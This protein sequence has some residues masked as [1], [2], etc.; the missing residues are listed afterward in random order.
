MNVKH[1]K[2]IVECYHYMY[3]HSIYMLHFSIVSI[4]FCCCIAKTGNQ[5]L[6]KHVTHVTQ[7][8]DCVVLKSIGKSVGFFVILYD[9]LMILTQ[10]AYIAYGKKLCSILQQFT[11]RKC[12][13]L[14]GAVL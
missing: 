10:L 14:F 7:M 12:V 3:K 9:K 8:T 4:F 1:R 2:L 13:T 6:N 11:G 5:P